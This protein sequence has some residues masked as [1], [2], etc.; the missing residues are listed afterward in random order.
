MFQLQKQQSTIAHLN[1]RTE[2]HGEEDVL[3]ADV[4]VEADVTND[5]LSY[6]NPTLKW[7]LYDKPNSGQGEL[8][9][10]DHHM[11]RLRYPSLPELRWAGKMEKAVF[12]IHG[13]KKADDLEFEAGV[14]KLALCCKEG[15]TVSITF[16]CAV[17]PT[18]EQSGQLAA[19][20]RSET[21]VSVREGERAD[22]PAG[23]DPADVKK[24]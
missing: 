21:K 16:R 10:D 22:D 15:G 11:P 8:I 23:E 13:K 19:L 24:P 2:K 6:L 1:I 7:S 14:D 12:I 20:L 9:K 17:L 3:A 5:F 18:P 4:K